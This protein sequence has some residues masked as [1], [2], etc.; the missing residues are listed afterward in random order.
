V[1]GSRG[2]NREEPLL[3][4]QARS[5]ARFPGPSL[6]RR[7][8]ASIHRMTLLAGLLWAAL[9]AP[10]ED[11][12]RAVER[13]RASERYQTE[14]PGARREASSPVRGPRATRRTE[15]GR[16][17]PDPGPDVSL[18]PIGSALLWLVVTALC[19]ALVVWLAL[20]W[21]AR[22]R[23]RAAT[24]ALAT[25]P[26]PADAAA[27]T[28][29]L[30]DHEV[31]A[32]KGEFTDAIHAILMLVLR[33]IGR[34]HAGMRPAWTS[35]EILRQVTLAEQPQRALTSLVRLVEVT[36]F[37]GAAAGEEE[38]RHALGWLDSI[39]AGGPA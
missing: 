26:A 21:R 34:A 13:V 10:P 7:G 8:D 25:A 31:L 6:F 5:G 3:R 18:A 35:R 11:V 14:L 16:F 37:G 17:N 4:P 29:P 22:S 27:A 9:A 36:R 39:G 19:A 28:A 12:Q 15:R 24:R 30:P 1:W 23:A 38:Y 20:E 32:R 2:P 33:T